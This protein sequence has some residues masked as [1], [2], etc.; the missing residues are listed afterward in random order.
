M[1]VFWGESEM[2]NDTT[3]SLAYL[4]DEKF[5]RFADK[6]GL[7]HETRKSLENM[8]STIRGLGGD[9]PAPATAPS[10]AAPESLDL[11]P[12]GQ[13]MYEVSDTGVATTPAFA[14]GPVQAG[15]A[16]PAPQRRGIDP[17]RMVVAGRPTQQS[18]SLRAS[19]PVSGVAGFGGLMTEAKKARAAGAEKLGEAQS[20][21]EGAQASYEAAAQREMEAARAQ[22]ARELQIVQERDAG[23]QNLQA[24][25][26]ANDVKRKEAFSAEMKKYDQLVS[27]AQGAAVDPDNWYKD[28][29]GSTNYGRKIGASIAMALGQFGA[30]LAGGPNAAMQI[31]QGAIDN[32]I[33]AQRDAI[34]GKRDDIDAQRTRMA[35]LRAQF[36][37][38]QKAELA[39]EDQYWGNY[40][41][42]LAEVALQSK[43]PQIQANY[44]KAK[45]AV[46]EKRA[47]IK[48]RF[49]ETAQAGIERGIALEGDLR[50]RQ[51]AAAMQRAE[52]AAK[53][54]GG[55]DNELVVPGVGVAVS[56][57]AAKKAIELKNGV[58]AL[59]RGIGDLLALR[60]KHGGGFSETLHPE[61]AARAEQIATGLKMQLK[62]AW[63]LGIMSDDE[64][65]RMD[66]VVAD[67]TDYGTP[68][69]DTPK[70]SLEQLRSGMTGLA[71]QAFKN[72]GLPGYQAAGGAP[73]SFR[74][75]GG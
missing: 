57:D 55:V 19:A 51:N 67:A 12:V 50:A 27:D 16:A 44:E 1:A 75:Q 13:P 39:L 38:D 11:G 43:D 2:T 20:E 18:V 53:T 58:D 28:P 60:E 32:D 3:Y 62:V 25:R 10:P 15:A 37:D 9:T 7:D 56:K 4:D 74:R 65:K 49:A 73:A 40:D 59:N 22:N 52:L 30:A 72:Y 71:D 5:N 41:R 6:A 42:Q 69:S 61:D 24:Q 17:E 35:D 68:W 64:Y 48:A 66:R 70:A 46:Q 63:Q 45:A 33:Q 36:G 34:K 14:P 8:R 29:D 23:L 54:Q 47:D 26:A 21:A 31:I